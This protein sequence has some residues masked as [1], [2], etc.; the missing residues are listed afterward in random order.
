MC[1]KT[2]KAWQRVTKHDRVSSA[3]HWGVLHKHMADVGHHYYLGR[4]VAPESCVT[5][6]PQSWQC[7]VLHVCNSLPGRYIILEVLY[8]PP[9]L[10]LFRM[11][12]ILS[13]AYMTLL[14]FVGSGHSCLGD[15]SM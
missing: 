15:S 13:A 3:I 7:L 12:Q 1:D 2:L 4:S 6:V 10:S 8:I 11:R 5:C 9:E 14:Q